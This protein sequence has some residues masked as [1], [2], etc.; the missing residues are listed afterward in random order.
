MAHMFEVI[1]TVEPVEFRWTDRLGLVSS[2]R[3]PMALSP[4]GMRA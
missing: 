4:A 3:R 1:T 2:I